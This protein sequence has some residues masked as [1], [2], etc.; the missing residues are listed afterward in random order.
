MGRNDGPPKDRPAHAV[1]VKS[2]LLEKTE[3]TNQEY[4]EFVRETNHAAPESF[5]NGKP[6]FGQEL[7]PV[8]NV[9]VD[10]AKAFAEWRSKRDGVTYRLPTDEEWEYAARGGDQDLLYPWGNDWVEGRAVVNQPFPKSVGSMP[11]GK[12][13]W[14]VLDMFGN[15]WEWTS[16]KWNVYP[17]NTQ[18]EVPAEYSSWIIKRG[19]SFTSLPNDKQLP[20]TNTFRDFAPATT[21]HPTI[22]FRLA[23]DA[24]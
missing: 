8:S 10:D 21:K 9:S 13:R 16:S 7:W 11:E 3:V 23:R 19:G 14:G 24:N 20:I 5:R 4:A 22:G 1:T 2:F 17:G 6:V 15:V 18:V 12:N